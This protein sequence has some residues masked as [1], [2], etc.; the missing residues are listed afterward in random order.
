[1]ATLGDAVEELLAAGEGAFMFRESDTNVQ[2][3]A[4]DVNAEDWYVQEDEEDDTDTDDT[5]TDASSEIED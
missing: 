5:A 1:M 3:N 4:D 2:L